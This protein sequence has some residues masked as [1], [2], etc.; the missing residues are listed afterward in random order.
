[1]ADGHHKEFPLGPVPAFPCFLLVRMPF[2]AQLAAV[3][4]F[5]STKL[6]ARLETIIGTGLLVVSQLTNF[7]FL[8][9]GFVQFYC[10]V[11]SNLGKSWQHWLAILCG[12]GHFSLVA[13]IVSVNLIT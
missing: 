2:V 7:A 12:A 8:L 9:S 11:Y 1:M 10:L 3:V 6:Q 4:V 13:Y 5:V